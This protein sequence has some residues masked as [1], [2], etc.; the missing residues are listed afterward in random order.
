[1]EK[2]FNK[3]QE[4]AFAK[5]GLKP[6][7]GASL[8]G[9]NFEDML[10][11]NRYM[12]ANGM[13]YAYVPFPRGIA[14]KRL[15][16][17][18]NIG[19]A[20]GE[21]YQKNRDLFLWCGFAAIAVN[22]GI[23]PGAIDSMKISGDWGNAGDKLTGDLAA[24]VIP[25]AQESAQDGAKA[26]FAGNL[27][28]YAD[29]YWVHL[30]YLDGG[31]AKLR[32][33]QVNEDV[34][35]TVEKLDENRGG[36]TARAKA[37]ISAANLAMFEYEQVKIL[38]PIFKYYGDV[39][40]L[41]SRQGVVNLPNQVIRKTARAAGLDPTWSGSYNGKNYAEAEPRWT[42]LKTVGWPSY[43][44]IRSSSD[45]YKEVSRAVLGEAE[46]R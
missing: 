8:L 46:R 35:K 20:Y 43:M 37:A 11:R 39:M 6:D 17:M 33:L 28:I 2:K 31:I 27:G 1:L 5:I 21:M 38:T 24:R 14:E 19:K 42:W 12:K 44:G 40:Q 36:E 15:E 41:A 4:A 13:T 34:L 23:L 30:A 29:L 25:R 18:K 32:E 16:I 7:E 45:D 3:Y 9:D 10:D 22:D 26:A